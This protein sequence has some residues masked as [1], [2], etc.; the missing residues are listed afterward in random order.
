[1]EEVH[2]FYAA[3]LFGYTGHRNPIPPLSLYSLCVSG[4]FCLFLQARGVNGAKLDDRQQEWYSFFYS[5][6]YNEDY[7][8]GKIIIQ[9]MDIPHTL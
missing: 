5:L 1:M 2:A 7:L 3:V 4:D 8:H 9:S 6:H